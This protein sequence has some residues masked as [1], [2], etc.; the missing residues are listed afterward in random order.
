[1]KTGVKLGAWIEKSGDVD[2]IV[3]KPH[4]SIEEVYP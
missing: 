3:G 4:R 1:M 2:Q